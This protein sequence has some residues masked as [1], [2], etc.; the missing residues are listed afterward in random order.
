[1]G[2][3]IPL[4]RSGRTCRLDPDGGAKFWHD[5]SMFERYTEGARKVIY[6]SRMEAGAY[7]SP[8][9]ETEHLLLGLIL[10]GDPQVQAVLGEAGAAVVREKV[11]AA[12]PPPRKTG[13]QDL[14]LSH[15][16]KRALAYAAEEAERMRSETIGA[17]HLLL[18]LLRE[19][20]GLAAQVSA[21]LKASLEAVRAAAR[22]DLH[23]SIY[24]SSRPPRLYGRDPW[25]S[26][27][28]R[29]MYCS[30]CST[31]RSRRSRSS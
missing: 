25:P 19:P 3:R 1:M 11:E 16:S 4:V 8:Q 14:P 5:S 18:G 6:F 17:L 9:I 28:R 27:R 23:G 20:R 10:E 7:G 30:R 26:R 31:I 24:P 22:R 12:Y 15:H 2:F 21:E 29:I 13:F